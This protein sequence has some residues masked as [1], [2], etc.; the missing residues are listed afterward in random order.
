MEA[1]F[2]SDL[3]PSFGVQK[4]LLVGPELRRRDILSWTPPWTVRGPRSAVL[5]VPGTVEPFGAP[6]EPRYLPIDFANRC[7][8][9]AG[10]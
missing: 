10:S 5:G 7:N 6:A 2:S 3:D 1:V 9:G 4:L 8:V